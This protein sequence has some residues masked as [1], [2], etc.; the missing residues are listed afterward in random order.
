MPSPVTTPEPENQDDQTQETLPPAPIPVPRNQ[1]GELSPSEEF[2]DDT[3]FGEPQSVMDPTGSPLVNE[4]GTPV[5]GRIVLD[6]E[7][8]PVIGP[9]GKPIIVIPD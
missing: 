9:N 5:I 2:D 6:E 3:Q 1:A 4:D 8:K 7:G